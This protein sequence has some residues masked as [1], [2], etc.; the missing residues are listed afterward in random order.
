MGRNFN[1]EVKMSKKILILILI[2][3]VFNLLVR[4]IYIGAIHDID[5][6]YFHNQ[7]MINNPD[8]YYYLEGARDILEN[9]HDN[10]LSPTNNVT[11]ILTAYISKFLHVPLDSVALYLPGV[12]GSLVVIPLVLIGELLGSAW[13]GF[14][15]ALM[16]PMV[17]SY[18]HRTMFGY[19][20]TDMLTVTLPMFALWAILYS[21]KRKKWFFLAPVIEIFM[22]MWHSGL[23]NVANGFFIMSFLYVLFLKFVKKEKVFEESKFLLFLII[24]LLSLNPYLKLLLVFALYLVQSKI[25]NISYLIWIVGA[26]YLLSIGLPWI[27]NVLHS[28][29]FTREK[30]IA[31]GGFKYFDVVNTVREAGKIDWN[32]FVHRISGSWVGFVLGLIG[33][34]LLLIRY[35]IMIISLPLVILGWFAL[36]GG[37][38]FTIFAVPLFSFG[39]AYIAYLI[40]DIISRKLKKFKLKYM[41]SFLI[42]IGFIYPNYKHIHEYI[43][44]PVFNK[45]EVAVLEKL[46]GIVNRNDYVLTWWD[47]GYIIRYYVDVKTLIDGGKHSGDVNYPVSFALTRP[48]LPSRNMAV[49][50]VYFT[51]KGEKDIIKAILKYYRLKDP[52]KLE[53]FLNQN[54]P[55]PNIRQNIYYFLPY[56]MMDIFPTVAVFSLIDL[57]TGKIKE[58]FFFTSQR[59][60]ETPKG[61]SIGGILLQGRNLIIGKNVVPIKSFDLVFYDKDGKL[62]VKHQDLF[63]VGLRVIYMK[64]YGKWL[65]IDDFYYNS[66]YIK[67]FVFEKYDPKLF[68]PV[69]L[70]PWAKVYKLIK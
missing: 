33:Y 12:F 6:F 39:N 14:L 70:S 38:R 15:A 1:K 60:V 59:A 45:E 18:Y 30:V 61:L 35:P 26:I 52:Q 63:K 2:A 69:I 32:V 54:I 47:Y 7:L 67:M 37:L 16:A 46:K 27:S 25:K 23:Y 62:V 40:S 44:P 66:S 5:A 19:F 21:L 55:L 4:F 43:M 9:K 11:S 13:L 65:I 34:V 51:E 68:K 56:R 41:L 50:D 10:P 22:I 28:S 53:N 36:R 17:W 3:Y 31:D 24:P 42:M 20:D 64:S 58:H 8:G 57:K 29:Y 49:L 48:E